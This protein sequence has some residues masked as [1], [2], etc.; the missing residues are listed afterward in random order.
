NDGSQLTPQTQELIDRRV[1]VSYWPWQSRADPDTHRPTR[2]WRTRS[3]AATAGCWVKPI[4]PPGCLIRHAVVPEDHHAATVRPGRVSLP[5][6]VN[7]RP[8]KRQRLSRPAPPTNLAIGNRKLFKIF[9]IN[10]VLQEFYL[11]ALRRLSLHPAGLLLPPMRHR[12]GR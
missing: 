10:A 9:S 2:W 5:A 4:S 12:A 8:N 1:R 7:V 11:N 3:A 6:L